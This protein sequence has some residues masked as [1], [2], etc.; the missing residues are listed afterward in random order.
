MYKKILA[1]SLLG[2]LFFNILGSFPL[3]KIA[4]ELIKKEMAENIEGFVPESELDIVVTSKDSHEIEWVK[5]GKEFRYRSNLYDV[6]KIKESKD[7]IK[8]YCIKDLKETNLVNLM[9]SLIKKEKEQHK[10]PL[11]SHTRK[12]SKIWFFEDGISQVLKRSYHSNRLNFYKY[13]EPFM[14]NLYL[15]KATPPPQLF[16]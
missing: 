7:Q 12:S 3:F 6:V 13:Q 15:D 10:N 5:K 2:M 16:S 11:S 8:Y 14:L 1:G 9:N 4:Q